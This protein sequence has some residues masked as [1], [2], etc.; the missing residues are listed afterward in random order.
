[1]EYDKKCFISDEK[2]VI[3]FNPEINVEEIEVT[4]DMYKKYFPKDESVDFK[5]LRLSNIGRYSIVNPEIQKN[6]IAQIEKDLGSTDKTITDSF[7]NMGGMAISFAKVFS[8]VNTCEIVPLHC[9]IL[10]NNIKE[11]G[12][13]DKVHVICGDYMKHMNKL[14]QDA[15]IFDPP[16]GGTDYKKVKKLQLSIN[17]VNVCCIINHLLAKTKFIYLMVPPNYN[18]SDLKLVN[19]KY[20]VQRIKLQ[21][22]RD[23]ASKILLVFSSKLSGGRRVTRRL[24]KRV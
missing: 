24:K 17:N 2:K 4:E 11:Y 9:E 21:P 16:W 6:I 19:S 7:G 12:L 23:K 22:E 3:P 15:I 13:A 8:K 18:F 10:K 14:K 1:M 5:K 20:N